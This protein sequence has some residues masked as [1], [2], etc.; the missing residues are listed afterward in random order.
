AFTIGKVWEDPESPNLD[1]AKFEDGAVAFKLLFTTATDT[2]VPFLANSFKW[3]ANVD[4]LNL[5]P[6]STARRPAD[7]LLLQVD[8][9]VRDDRAET[10]TGWVF[11]TFMY[12]NDAPGS[13]PFERLVPVGLMWGN[14]PGLTQVEYDAGQRPTQTWLNK[15]GT[16]PTKLTKF[17]W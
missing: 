6:A 14:D 4:L 3:Q 8:V 10:T 2:Q 17:G 12:Q 11:G 9:A 15:D 13:T 7:V 1:A 5:S 16:P